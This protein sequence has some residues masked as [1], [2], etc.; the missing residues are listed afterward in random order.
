[1]VAECVEEEDHE[2]FVLVYGAHFNEAG[3]EFNDLVHS[4]AKGRPGDKSYV[5]SFFYDFDLRV[6]SL[7]LVDAA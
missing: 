6:Q 3:V 5:E 1:M 4:A 7:F 2:E